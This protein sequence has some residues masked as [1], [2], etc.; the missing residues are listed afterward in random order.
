MFAPVNLAFLLF[1]TKKLGDN[2]QVFVTGFSL[3][4]KSLPNNSPKIKTVIEDAGRRLTGI[5]IAT[6]IGLDS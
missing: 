6:T 1:S 3:T 4:F 5:F 2:V